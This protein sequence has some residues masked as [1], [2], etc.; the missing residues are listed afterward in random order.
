MADDMGPLAVI[1]RWFAAHG[2]KDLDAASQLMAPDAPIHVP[3]RQL[4]GFAGLMRWYEERTAASGDAFRYDVVDLLSGDH[5]VAAVLAL[6][7]GTR[8]WQ[9]F[10]LYRVEAGLIT[11]VTAYE[12]GP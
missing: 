7:D 9:Q 2:A 3:G 11:A 4:I 1:R 12:D 8:S 6:T 10:A 5:H